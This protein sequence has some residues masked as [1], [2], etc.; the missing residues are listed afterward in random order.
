M[1]WATS[2]TWTD[3][4]L[5]TNVSGHDS[6]SRAPEV[7][8]QATT[9]RERARLPRNFSK[10]QSSSELL[11]PGSVHSGTSQNFTLQQTALHAP[12]PSSSARNF[13]TWCAPRARA[14][15]CAVWWREKG[16]SSYLGQEP[17]AGQTL[18]E[19]ALLGQRKRSR[20]D[21]AGCA[22]PHCLQSCSELALLL[23]R[24]FS[25]SASSTPTSAS[26][27]FN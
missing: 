15:E 22:L 19:H 26:N 2:A 23:D 4:V 8:F 9:T 14:H 11:G 21:P 3:S 1:F 20:T 5:D 17:R 6:V 10:P 24:Y 16:E 25:T 27:D 18:K 13:R 12:P 7:F